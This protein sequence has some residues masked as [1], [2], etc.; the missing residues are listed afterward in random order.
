[1]FAARF[2]LAGSIL[3]LASLPAFAQRPGRAPSA[4]PAFLYPVRPP[5]SVAPRFLGQRTTGIQ[6]G[7]SY[8]LGADYYS[9]YYYRPTPE[10]GYYYLG[11]YYEDTPGVSVRT[12]LSAPPPGIVPTPN[13]AGTSSASPGYTYPELINPAANPTVRP[14][15]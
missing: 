10:Y 8:G 14:N 7:L 6:F 1:M 13:L 5:L 2:V 15:R 11:N 12:P 3:L 4:G 9:G